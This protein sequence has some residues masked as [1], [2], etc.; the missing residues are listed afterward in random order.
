MDGVELAPYKFLVH[1]PRI[2]SGIP[3]RGGYARLAAWAY[4][5]KG[6]TLKDW[7]AF[8]EVFGMP[9]RLGKYGSGAKKEDIDILKMAVANLGTDAAAVFPQSME[10]E[11]VEASKSGSTD[12]FER[13]AQYLDNQVTKGILGQT[14]TT[15]GTPGK[16]GNEEAQN[17]VR[18]DFRDD[19][20]EQ[21]EETLQ[22]DLV[23]PFVDLNFGPQQNYPQIQLRAPQREDIAGLSES[24]SKLVPLGLRVSASVIRD[25]LGLPDP[26][27][28][29]EILMPAAVSTATNAM[30]LNRQAGAD[31]L[32]DEIDIAADEALDGWEAAG[33]MAAIV[34]PIARA[35]DAS[36]SVEAFA[37]QLEEIMRGQDAVVLVQHLAAALF[38]ARA[39]G[40]AD[41]G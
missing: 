9:L 38:K 24:L 26:D 36:D 6:Y 12:F 2:K 32:P 33:G 15:Q 41:E 10:I 40:A 23:V 3:I 20:A 8:A 21:L 30:A 27:E 11:L 29:E 14:A 25:K 1:T 18:H 16:L 28:D 34:S 37:A 4:M 22:R 7:L 5:C 31:E 39:M 17:E 35:L 13:L 19:D